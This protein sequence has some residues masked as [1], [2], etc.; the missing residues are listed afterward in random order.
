VALR[1]G[2][3]AEDFEANGGGF[4]H[5]GAADEWEL[6]LPT[7]APITTCHSG[8]NCWKTDL[9]NT[10]NNAPTGQR[11]DQELLSPNISL[12]AGDGHQ[13]TFE[14]AMKYS[15]EGSNWENAFVEVREVGNPTNVKRVW[16]WAGP[17]MT[18]TVGSP[19]VTLNSAAGWS[20]WQ[21]DISEFGGKTVQLV[22][23]LDQDD[24]VALTGIA[25]DDVSVSACRRAPRGDFDGDGWID[26]S[27]FRPSNSTWYI[28]N[29]FD[30]TITTQQ[31]GNATDLPV[32]A[33]YDGDGDIDIAVFR[34][35]EGAWYVS[36]GSGQNFNRVQW[37]TNG[38]IPVLGDYD[39]DGKADFAVFRPGDATW[40]VLR[41][42]DSGLTGTQWGISTDKPVPADYDGDGR[43]DFAVFRDGEWWILNSDVGNVT[44]LRLGLATDEPVPADYDGDGKFDIAVWRP[45]NGTWYSLNSSINALDVVQWGRMGDRPVP[46]HYKGFAPGIRCFRAVFRPSEGIWYILY[47]DLTSFGLNWGLAGDIPVPR[48]GTIPD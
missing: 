24:S 47:P 18:R 1:L 11:V 40:Y 22:F 14:W 38:D 26:F 4:T 15:I 6:G 2:L 34:P 27:V 39:G 28:L 12:A 7:F 23:H 16:E 13:I 36:L 43:T 33:D 44:S 35:S 5:S 29:S 21:A 10:Y 19:A 17:T 25:I 30:S 9:D 45:S 37:G 41:S 20:T 32:P 42:S 46:G 8:T 3:F 31:F 48:S